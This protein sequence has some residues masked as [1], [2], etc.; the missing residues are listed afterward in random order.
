MKHAAA[1]QGNTPAEP[2]GAAQASHCGHVELPS[3]PVMK[4]ATPLTPAVGLRRRTCC[5]A[6]L[7]AGV[8]GRAVRAADDTQ[9]VIE[10]LP[11][12]GATL[13]VQF[14]PGFDAAQR[15][16]LLD[17]VRLEAA[18]VAGW[19]GRFPVPAAELLLLPVAGEGVRSGV[20]F[21]EPSPWLRVTVGRDTSAAQLRDDWV[22]AHEMVHLA[23]PQ[24]PRA[25]RWLH[26]GIATYVESLARGAAGLVTPARVWGQW[27]R[28]MA[29]GQPAA[30]D[31]GLDRTPTWGRTYWG[32]ALF[33]LLADVR[34]RQRG[35]LQRGLQQALQG[36]LAGGGDYRV[37]WPAT[38]VLATADA[39][40]GQTTLMELYRQMNEPAAP[41]IELDAL[42]RQLGVDGDTL[43]D[44]AP[45]AAL[46]R[47]ILG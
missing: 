46:R 18:A 21:G 16:R 32:G 23:V 11:V 19:F 4:P 39:T 20:S 1:A 47:A 40:L 34:L 38:R 25:Q 35:T 7:A 26:E 45:L 14:E 24:L 2:R 6:L 13:E 44:D 3:A 15:G 10:M 41:P 27:S 30:G 29:Q 8:P 28:A 37:A 36:V 17:W 42:W 22:L 5:V 31:Q 43:R 33:C 12:P 9:P